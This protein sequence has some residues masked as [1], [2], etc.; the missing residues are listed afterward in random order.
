MPPKP[1][2]GKKGA[3]EVDLSD[4]ASLPPINSVTFTL[5]FGAFFS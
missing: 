2:P 3:D 5:L 1:A 4:V